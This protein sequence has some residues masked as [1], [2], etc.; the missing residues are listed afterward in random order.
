METESIT[1]HS[2]QALKELERTQMLQNLGKL[3]AGIAH[4]INTPIQFIGD[5]LRF[6]SESFDDI[7]K[8]VDNYSQMK[9]SVESLVSDE[10]LEK[11]SRS[12]DKADLDF[13]SDE[14]PQ[15][16]AQS[17]EGVQRVSAMVMAMRAF[18]HIVERRFARADLNKA[19][20]STIVILRNEIKY[21]ADVEKHLDDR[22]GDVVCCVDE[23]Q[24]VFL[25]LTINAA[26]SIKEKNESGGG[27]GLI[28]VCS[29]V[30]GGEAVFSV[31]DT[32]CGITPE[33]RERMFEPFY[34]T[35]GRNG[36]GQ[37]LSIIMSVLKKH[38][39][40]IEVDSEVGS[41]TTFTVY[42][43]IEGECRNE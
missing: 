20:N 25:N 17:I 37:G 18:S 4:E 15:A 39:G 23:M 43:P 42:I 9:A 1:D 12:E 2:E 13:I 41:G 30:E 16:I 10:M 40:R 34:T 11:I 27:R 33:V 19:I 21:V 26:H 5:N 28:T 8:L 6:L 3:T 24:Q 31:S 7:L 14:V 38:K 36:T 32:G 22:L 35:K 29:R